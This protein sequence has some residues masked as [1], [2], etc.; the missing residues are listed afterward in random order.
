MDLEVSQGSGHVWKE[1]CGRRAAD[2]PSPCSLTFLELK[3]LYPVGSLSCRK[4]RLQ[5]DS[6][7]SSFPLDPV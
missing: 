6:A 2:S 3:A 4:G 5:S 1:D 7:S